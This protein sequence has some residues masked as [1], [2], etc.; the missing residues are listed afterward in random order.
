MKEYESTMQTSIRDESSI[1]KMFVVS[2]EIFERASTKS[3][4]P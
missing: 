4:Y 3:E 2:R 1:F